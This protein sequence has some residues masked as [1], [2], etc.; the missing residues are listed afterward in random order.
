[1]TRLKRASL[2]GIVASVATKRTST[3]YI[4]TSGGRE[5]MLTVIL[6]KTA[7]DTGTALTG[8]R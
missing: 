4:L 6:V 5:P 1:M 8:V 3:P 7:G 2:R